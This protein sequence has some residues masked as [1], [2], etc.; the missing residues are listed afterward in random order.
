MN[1]NTYCIPVRIVKFVDERFPGWVQSE[2]TDA[3]GRNHT[4]IDKVPMFTSENLDESSSYPRDGIARCQIL[5]R[6]RD[7]NNHELVLITIDRPDTMES[8]EG[9]SEF[10]VLAEQIR[11]DP[12]PSPGDS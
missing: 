9:L 8:T 12:W 4:L 5:D 11:P 3:K 2:F 1:S 7:D 6:S 10:I